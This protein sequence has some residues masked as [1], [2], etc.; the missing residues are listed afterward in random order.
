[1]S[2]TALIEEIK[3]IAAEQEQADALVRE[4]MLACQQAKIMTRKWAN[5]RKYHLEVTV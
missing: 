1:M 5:I 4:N 3:Q 2:T